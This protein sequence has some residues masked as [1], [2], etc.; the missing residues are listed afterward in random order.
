MHIRNFRHHAIRSSATT[1]DFTTIPKYVR[2]RRSTYAT[3]VLKQITQNAEPVV[4]SFSFCLA[5]WS[6]LHCALFFCFTASSALCVIYFTTGCVFCVICFSTG[7]AFCVV[8]FQYQ[9]C[10]LWYFLECR[11]YFLPFLLDT[12]WQPRVLHMHEMALKSKTLAPN[13]VLNQ[14]K[15]SKST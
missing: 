9:F 15:R 2:I 14:N 7:Y 1:S 4:K 11:F 10:F 13:D 8:C 3:S 12:T 5:K 6:A